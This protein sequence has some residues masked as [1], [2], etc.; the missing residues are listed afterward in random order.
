MLYS[1]ARSL[2]YRAQL[3]AAPFLWRREP[4]HTLLL[5][6]RLLG[7]LLEQLQQSLSAS[8]RE[9]PRGQPS[10]WDT[11]AGLDRRD[12]VRVLGDRLGD[13]T[14]PFSGVVGFVLTLHVLPSH[15][16]VLYRNF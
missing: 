7:M 9:L 2:P 15:P 16:S 8:S 5:A 10:A 3:G 1:Q 6:H 4:V 11:G 13:H 14:H 12:R